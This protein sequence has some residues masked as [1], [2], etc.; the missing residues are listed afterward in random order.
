MIGDPGDGPYLSAMGVS[1]KLEVNAG[2][3]CALQM[4]GLMVENNGVKRM[5]RG[6][7]HEVLQW[8]ATYVSTVIAPNNNDAA[9][10]DGSIV[11]E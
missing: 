11:Y 9:I 7:S 2:S 4:I 3:L 6:R 10:N 1:A 8:F 5:R